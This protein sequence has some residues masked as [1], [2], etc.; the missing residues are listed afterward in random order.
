MIAV[1]TGAKS[2]DMSLFPKEK[3]EIPTA[4]LGEKGERSVILDFL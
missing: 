1:E 4:P 2:G 3:E